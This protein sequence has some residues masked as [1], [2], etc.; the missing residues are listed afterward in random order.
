MMRFQLFREAILNSTIQNKLTLKNPNKLLCCLKKSRA[1]VY[2]YPQNKQFMETVAQ[3]CELKHFYNSV[4]SQEHVSLV[5]S[6]LHIIP[7]TVNVLIKVAL[8]YSQ[9]IFLEGFFLKLL[10]SQFSN[11]LHQRTSWQRTPLSIHTY[12]LYTRGFSILPGMTGEVCSEAA[13]SMT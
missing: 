2:F 4:Y 5:N 10:L 12:Q 8:W 13:G 1:T 9:D 11:T 6:E 7:K 3:Q